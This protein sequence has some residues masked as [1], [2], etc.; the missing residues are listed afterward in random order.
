MPSTTPATN[1]AQL[2]PL[3]SFGV[4]MNL[5]TSTAFSMIISVQS[6]TRDTYTTGSK[7]VNKETK[8]EDAFIFMLRTLFQGVGLLSEENF[9]NS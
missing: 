3:R 8:G 5:F 6:T 9:P 7:K 2:S 1:A 4:E